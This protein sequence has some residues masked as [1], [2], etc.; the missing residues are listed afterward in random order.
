MS[1][2]N[3]SGEGHIV[4]NALAAFGARHFVQKVGRKWVV[5]IRG[6][7]VP[8]MFATRREAVAYADKAVTAFIEREA[9]A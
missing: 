8:T 2:V 9:R 3:L 6:Y 4:L 5:E 1:L 7:R